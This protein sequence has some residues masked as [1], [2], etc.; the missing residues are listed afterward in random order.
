[1][2]KGI[3]CV[4]LAVLAMMI[5]GCGAFQTPSRQVELYTPAYPAPEAVKPDETLPARLVVKPFRAS[6]PYRTDRMVYAD[7]AY[8][9]NTYTYH[10]WISKP[11]EMVDSFIV[12]DIRAA[13]IAAAVCTDACQNPT[14]I[15]E[16]T[17]TEFYEDDSR[18]PWTA[19]LAISITLS[20]KAPAASDGPVLLQKTYSVHRDLEQNNPLGFAKAMSRALETVSERMVA[21]IQERLKR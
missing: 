5:Q 15:L 21:D 12:R 17:V 6:A 18:D 14:H 7:N 2:K 16:G 19:V 9:R 4:L 1:M 3:F 13:Q 8:R 20:E 10:R 11:A